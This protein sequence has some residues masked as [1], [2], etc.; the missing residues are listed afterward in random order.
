MKTDNSFGLLC[1]SQ[2]SQMSLEFSPRKELQMLRDLL[3]LPIQAFAS[4]I[5]YVQVPSRAGICRVLLYILNTQQVNPIA[6]E[7]SLNRI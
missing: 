7:V 3:Q 1:L 2:F 6:T 4:R 5:Q